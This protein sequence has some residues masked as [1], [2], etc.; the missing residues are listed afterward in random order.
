VSGEGFRDQVHLFG[1]EKKE[2]PYGRMF[3]IE[4]KARKLYQVSGAVGGML[5]GCRE[6]MLA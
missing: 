4:S 6:A 5:R 1:E 3:V 2:A